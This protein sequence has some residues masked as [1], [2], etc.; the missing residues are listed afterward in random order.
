MIFLTGAKLKFC[1]RDN[2]AVVD[3]F[4]LLL[5]IF[6]PKHDYFEPFLTLHNMVLL[7]N[8]TRMDF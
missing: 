7:N 1:G 8:E 3:F 4:V 5:F 6:V 2:D